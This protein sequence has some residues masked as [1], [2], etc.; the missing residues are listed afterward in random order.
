MN[1][2]DGGG[3]RYLEPGETE[4][5]LGFD[6][7]LYLVIKHGPGR[8]DEVYRGVFA[9]L[10]FPVSNP[11]GFISLLQYDQ[12]GHQVEIG[13][14][15]DPSLFPRRARNLLARSLAGYYFEFEIL[16][17]HRVRLKY[18]LLMFDVSTNHG[19]RQFEMR[20]KNETALDLGEHGKILL[21]IYDCRYIIRDLRDL[22]AQDRE[23]FTRFIY[24]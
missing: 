22:P 16:R 10:S 18:N 8:E 5:L 9:I 23:I 1:R 14:I 12:E 11:H 4:I 15:K 17:V 19:L 13:V 20:W 6:D 7:L 21:D 3:I 2:P 24:W